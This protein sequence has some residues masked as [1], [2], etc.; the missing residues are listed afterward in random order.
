M[1]VDVLRHIIRIMC[2]V[3]IYELYDIEGK[4]SHYCVV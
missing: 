2:C 1:L 3:F 4:L